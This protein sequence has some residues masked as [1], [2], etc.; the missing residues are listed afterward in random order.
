MKSPETRFT[1]DE[2]RVPDQGGAT[3]DAGSACEISIVSEAPPRRFA[4]R[5][6]EEREETL[7]LQQD[8]YRYRVGL[9]E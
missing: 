2:F 9:N 3:T 1:I 4:H 7:A 6:E 5:Y 8:R